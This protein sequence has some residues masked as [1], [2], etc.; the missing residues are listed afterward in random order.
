VPIAD[1]G[2]ITDH[3]SVHATPHCGA[4]VPLDLA[5]VFSAPQIHGAALQ[6]LERPVGVRG[7]GLAIEA[8]D[9]AAIFYRT[10]CQRTDAAMPPDC[11]LALATLRRE[12]GRWTIRARAA[13]REGHWYSATE[14]W[15]PGIVAAV[16]LGDVGGEQSAFSAWIEDGPSCDGELELRAADDLA[17]RWRGMVDLPPQSCG[18]PITPALLGKAVHLAVQDVDC[19]G[20]VDLVFEQDGYSQVYLF[21]PRTHT[22]GRGEEFA[23]DG[24]FVDGQFVRDQAQ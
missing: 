21:A 18:S 16:G 4:R 22:F 3:S 5:A 12:R 11:E 10:A 6:A 8:A 19:D 24:G 14:P 2:P 13:V 20:H 1:H 17:L 9:Q 23:P 15:N 7:G